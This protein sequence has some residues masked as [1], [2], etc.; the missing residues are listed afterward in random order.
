MNTIIGQYHY[1]GIKD[2]LIITSNTTDLFLKL[3]AFLEKHDLETKLI[4][5]SYELKNNIE[6]LASNNTDPVQFPILHCIV[7]EK[8]ADKKSFPISSFSNNNTFLFNPEIDKKEY[9]NRVNKIK[10]HIQLG[11]IYETN[12]CY[13]WTS[14]NKLLNPQE[15]FQKLNALTKA[16]F[17]VYADLKNH[18]ILCASPERFIKKKG[19]KLI[20]QPIKGT[21]KKVANKDLDKKIIKQLKADPKER[22]ENIMIVDLVRNDLSKIATKN[23]VS[24]D[25]LCKV[26]SFENIHQ[27]ISTVSCKTHK[28]ISFSTILKAL[29]PMGSMT[30]V[31]KIKA[32]ELMEHYE[33]TKRGLYSG[34]IGIIHPGGDFDLNVVIRTLIYN[35]INQTLSFNVGGAITID[36][37]PEKEYE[38]TLVKADALIKA[39][40]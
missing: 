29:F 13:G 40:E 17:S 30:G 31:P 21:A 38:E 28:N 27:L 16:P 18:V 11:D 34:S 32:M 23:S 5:L 3:D 2:E 37:N 39:C 6:N 1:S 15:L 14:K 25:E 33:T 35:K 20:S 24:V 19:D 36:S 4:F 7:P 26:Y 22:T 12:F 8:I 10:E 9:L